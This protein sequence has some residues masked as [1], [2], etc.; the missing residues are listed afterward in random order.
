MTSFYAETTTAS[1]LTRPVVGHTPAWLPTTAR[2]AAAHPRASRVARPHEREYGIIIMRIMVMLL[3]DTQNPKS[4][5][6]ATNAEWRKLR[7][8]CESARCQRRTSVNSTLRSRRWVPG[9]TPRCRWREP[10]S[11]SSWLACP[12]PPASHPCFSPSFLPRIGRE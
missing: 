7:V 3:L 11:C 6:A 1:A 5:K 12:H 9:E 8:G 4:E 2:T 10:S